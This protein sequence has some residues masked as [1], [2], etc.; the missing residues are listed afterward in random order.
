MSEIYYQV[1]TRCVMDTSDPNIHFDSQ[2]VCDHCHDFDNG[3]KQHL[4]MDEKK[5]LELK[6]ILEKIKKDGRGKKYDC[7]LG[8]SGG[9]DSSYMLHVAIKEFGLRPLVFHVDGGWNSELSLHNIKVMVD[10]LGIDLYTETINWDEMRDFQLAFFKSGVP[11]LDIPQ[12][13]A[14]IATLYQYAEKHHIKYILNGGNLSTECVQY[15]MKWFYY[16][17]DMLHINDIIKKFGT[18]SMKTYPFSSILKHKVYL[19]YLK[20]VKVIK[21]LNFIPFYKQEVIDFLK[22]EY[23]WREYPQKHFESIFTKFYEGYWLYE[24]FGYD[25]RRI[26]FSSLILTNQMKREDAIKALEHPPYN[27]ATII[28]EFDNVASKLGITT[29]ELRGYFDLPKKYYW[30]YKNQQ[31][32]FRLGAKVLHFFGSEK[33]KKRDQ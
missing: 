15:P 14:F 8:M 30:D 2:G 9:L 33:V 5:Q 31:R 21:P 29:T 20:G 28:E 7:L 25:T 17:T 24:R 18:I 4:I 11:H 23:N 10:K 1:C 13:H 12:D 26:Q 19:R 6:L 16:G 3:I 27:Q 22:K 32:L